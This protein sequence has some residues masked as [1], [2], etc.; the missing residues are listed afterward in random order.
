MKY[1]NNLFLHQGGLNVINDP[2]DSSD[3]KELDEEIAKESACIRILDCSQ[4]SIYHTKGNRS[5][6]GGLKCRH[7]LFARLLFATNRPKNLDFDKLIISVQQ[8]LIFCQSEKVI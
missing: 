1:F 8:K 7:S 6:G 5:Y 4:T 3:E 2:L